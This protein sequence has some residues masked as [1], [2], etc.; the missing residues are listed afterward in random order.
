MNR[1][2][3]AALGF[4]TSM[5]WLTPVVLALST[6]AFFLLRSRHG[7]WFVPF[8][9]ETEHLLGGRFL[10]NGG[11]LYQTYIDS[12]GPVIF[13]LTQLY[14]DFAGWSAPNYARLICSGMFILAA[15]TLAA[16]PALHDRTQRLWAASLFLGMCSS[17]WLVQGF[18]FVSYY[19]VAGALAAMCLGSFVAADWLEGRQSVVSAAV[20]GTTMTLLF[21]TAYSY[22]PSAILFGLSGGLATWRRGNHRA[23]RHFLTSAVVA[24]LLVLIWLLLYGDIVGYV[25]FH[26]AFNQTAY[27]AFIPLTPAHF[28]L[29]LSPNFGA[30]GIVNTIGVAACVISCLLF[31]ALTIPAQP[32]QRQKLPIVL[33]HLGVLFLNLRGMTTFQDG[34]FL[35]AAFGLLSIAV[36][37]S[38]A[39]IGPP[40]RRAVIVGS[41]VVILIIASSEIAARRARSTPVDLT[42]SQ[43]AAQPK[44]RV[45]LRL[46]I[47]IM[48]RLRQ[49]LGPRERV[50]ALPYWPDFYWNLDRMPMESFYEYLPWDA[51]YAHAPW[52]GRKRD[53]CIALEKSPPAMIALQDALVWGRFSI[54]QYAPCLRDVLAKSY[55]TVPGFASLYLRNDRYSEFRKLETPPPP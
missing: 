25:T 7:L 54:W 52:F 4:V 12:H 13:M 3:R 20:G 34:T 14:G 39:H 51:V 50:L 55:Q 6:L 49:V 53:W 31:L 29:S 17:V 45:A 33:A 16:S 41:L 19:P 9:D 36:P 23:I 38:L 15:A 37:L 22:G 44:S 48:E 46:E 10:D 40:E 26:I 8:V 27:A 21:F 1:S 18:Y 35:V 32:R 5:V 42:R 24:T 2:T 11:R 43:L 30:A 47:P 28:L